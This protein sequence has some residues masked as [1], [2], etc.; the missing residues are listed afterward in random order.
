LKRNIKTILLLIFFVAFATWIY[1]IIV[2]Y[3]ATF[4]IPLASKLP[5][6]RMISGAWLSAGGASGAAICAFLA[7]W[8]LGYLTK[9]KPIIVGTAL[10]LITAG[11]PLSVFIT[12]CIQEGFNGF[13]TLIFVVEQLTFVAACIVF[14]CW[15][16]HIARKMTSRANQE[17]APGQKTAR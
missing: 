6:T 11:L 15:G 12:T 4:Y 9:E 1:P 5:R 2:G 7:A 10:G 3:W 17:D 13:V 14:T 8:P 16:S